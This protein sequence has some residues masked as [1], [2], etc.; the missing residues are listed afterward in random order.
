MQ[1]GAAACSKVPLHVA[2]EKGFMEIAAAL[3]SFG[4]NVNAQDEY[5]CA[6]QTGHRTRTQRTALYADGASHATRSI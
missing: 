5:G 2:A 6:Q 4:A 3:L 1:Q